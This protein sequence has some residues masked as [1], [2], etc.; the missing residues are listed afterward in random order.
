M[1]LKHRQKNVLKLNKEQNAKKDV[2]MKIGSHV[3]MSAPD[4]VLGSVKEALSYGANAFMLYSG[5]PQNTFRQP[6]SKLKIKEAHVFMEENNIKPEEVM[7]VGDQLMTDVR[8]ANG[9]KIRCI[10][11][12]KKGKSPD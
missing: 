1:K 12:E 2:N 11:C 8:A 10:Y 5:A 4:F 7:M 3:S 9:A 6:L